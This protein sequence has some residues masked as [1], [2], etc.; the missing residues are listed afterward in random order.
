MDFNL[1]N[2]AITVRTDDAFQLTLRLPLLGNEFAAACRKNSCRWP[3]KTCGSCSRQESCP[4]NLVFG[5]NL[6]SDPSAL[7]RFQKPPLPFMFTFPSLH[8]LAVKATEIECGMVIIGQAI[9]CLD[10]LL[11]GFNDIL[12]PLAAEVH[13][14]GTR[15]YQGIVH[16]LG[17]GMGIIYPENLVVLSINDLSDNRVWP[18]SHLHIQLV[19]PLRL[20]EEGHLLGHFDFSRFARSLLRRVSSL[21]YYYGAHEIACDYKELSCQA[22]AVICTDNHFI[23]ATERNRKTAGITGDGRFRGDFGGLLPFLI[24]GL[25]VHVGKGSAFGMGAYELFEC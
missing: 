25:Y 15:D 13:M 11:E 14:V 18:D 1:V 2:L 16:P 12:V 5:Q 21:A 20:F 3:E 4:W 7:K 19:S 8:D 24:A 23:R 22:D 6:S 9:P 17:D 10:L